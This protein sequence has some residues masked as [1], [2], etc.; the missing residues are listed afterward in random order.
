MSFIFFIAAVPKD[1]QRF[2]QRCASTFYFY[3]VRCTLQQAMQ[4]HGSY[5]I[6]LFFERL[7]IKK[8]S[9]APQVSKTLKCL[10]A[11]LTCKKNL[12]DCPASSVIL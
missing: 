11:P 9:Q 8:L 2:Q 7:K 6:L 12:F 10:L 5:A 1:S 3:A 4:Q